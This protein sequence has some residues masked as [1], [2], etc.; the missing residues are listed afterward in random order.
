M[1]K[2]ALCIDNQDYPASLILR[3]AYRVIEPEAKD[4]AEW[5]RIIDESGED[6][7]FPAKRFVQ[8][9]VSDQDEHLIE[10]ATAHELEALIA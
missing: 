3:K 10:Q 2:R 7:L 5:L 4:P 9:E 1:K 8:F 6:Y